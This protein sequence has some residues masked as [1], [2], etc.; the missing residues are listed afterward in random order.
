MLVHLTDIHLHDDYDFDLLLKRNDALAGAL[1]EQISDQNTKMFLCITGDIVFSGKQDEYTAAGLIFDDLCEN[2]KNRF[3][4]VDIQFIFVPGNHDCDFTSSKINIRQAILSSPNCNVY[5]E[6]IFKSLTDIQSSFFC[7]L[8]EFGLKYKTIGCKNNQII[9]IYNFKVDDWGYRLVFHCINTSFCSQK[10]ETK[11]SLRLEIPSI[12]GKDERDIIFAM[13]HHDAEWLNW[14]DKRKWDEYSQAYPDVLMVGHDHNSEIIHK[15]YLEGSQHEYIKGE[16]L[17][18]KSNP[19][20]SGFNICKLKINI[21]EIQKCLIEYMWNG[22]IYKSRNVPKWEPF[23]RNNG[24]HGIRL[25][26]YMQDFIN[27]ID[28]DI[29]IIPNHTLILSDIFAFPTLAE[30][31]TKR[32]C[33]VRDMDTFISYISCNKNVSIRGNREYGKTSLLKMA[34]KVYFQMGKFPI[35]IDASSL[36]TIDVENLNK[37]LLKQYEECYEGI[38]AEEITQKP[39]SEKICFIDNFDEINLDDK[40]RTKLLKYLDL[41]FEYL[42]I[43]NNPSLNLVNPLRC[44]ETNEYLRDKFH[45]LVIQEVV[46]SYKERI[47]N[48]W[49]LS[50]EPYCNV[51]DSSFDAKRKEIYSKV[52][53]VMSNNFFNSTPMDFILV[54]SYLEQDMPTQV[55]YSRYSYI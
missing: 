29:S 35:I 55:N 50:K 37:F 11:G 33:I 41:H 23:K 3:P 30:I 32:N 45:V 9:S 6:E 43:T 17:Y 26:K 12:H 36:K 5:D 15:S 8:K 46:G 24:A 51:N 1:C 54:L 4:S 28:I 20:Q 40:S 49:I 25:T 22:K 27:A 21:H 18:D 47:I 16:K 53:V 19:D 14:N 44:V 31:D 52:Q 38:E 13:M 10:I 34:Y 2:I 42:I 48:Q 7:F 39:P